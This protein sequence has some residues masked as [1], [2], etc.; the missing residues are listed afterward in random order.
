LR[1]LVPAATKIAVLTNP[2]LPNTEAELRAVEQAAEAIGQQ[3]IVVQ[4]N[5][6]R[7]IEGA[8]E[9]FN[10]VPVRCSLALVRF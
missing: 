8:F 6:D 5:N 2:A 9:N 1:E 7:D 4:A 10:A 3:L